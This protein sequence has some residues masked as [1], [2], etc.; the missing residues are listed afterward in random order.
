VLSF[1]QMSSLVGKQEIG[2]KARLGFGVIGVVRNAGKFSAHARLSHN[3]DNWKNILK[4][5]EGQAR[6]AL[7]CC[8]VLNVA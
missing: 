5:S 8:C 2:Q 3:A 1:S 4:R 6:F 7:H